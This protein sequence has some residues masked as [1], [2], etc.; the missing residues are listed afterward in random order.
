MVKL[1][2]WIQAHTSTIVIA[3]PGP[4]LCTEQTDMIQESNLFTIAIGDVGRVLLTKADIHYHCDKKWWEYYNGCPESNAAFKAALEP[5]IHEFIY[6]TPATRIEPGLELNYPY[7]VTGNNSGY[8]AINLAVHF[9]P[10][11]II[12]VGYD[13]QDREQG[14]HNIIGDHPK[15]IKRPTDFPKFRDSIGTLV[16][17]LEDLGIK[18]Y[19]CTIDTALNCFQKRD[20]KDV[21]RA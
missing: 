11:T 20:L 2:P 1:L 17:P 19:N 18:V 14:V 6:Q 8:Q 12:L 4:S 15:A 10:K 16:K 9:K 7:L 5:T 3:A 13:M 21:L